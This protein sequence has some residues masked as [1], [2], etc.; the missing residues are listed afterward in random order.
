MVK[1]D[2]RYNT[3]SHSRRPSKRRAGS[4]DEAFIAHRRT[5]IESD[6]WQG[7][8]LVARRILD[9]LELEHLDHAGRE[10]GQL[11]VTHDDFARFGIRRK[12]VSAGLS[13]VVLRGLV[14]VTERGRGGNADFRRASRYRLTYLPTILD[15]PTDEWRSFVESTP[16][17]DIESRGENAP[18]TVGAKTP[19]KLRSLRGENAPETRG[20]SAPGLLNFGDRKN[21]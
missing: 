4:I 14:V 11:I 7:L 6:A 21:A 10:N 12:S 1:R 17:R 3:G 19:P 9:R 15:A 20:E 13:E 2:H 8:S 18:G 5:L 16:D